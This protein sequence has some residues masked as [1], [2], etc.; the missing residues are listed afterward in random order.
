VTALESQPIEAQGR[1]ILQIAE[2]SSSGFQIPNPGKFGPSKGSFSLATEKE[3]VYL[4]DDERCVREA[5]TEMLESSGMRVISFASATEYL[6]YV[7]GDEPSCVVLDMRLPDMSGLEL[8]TRLSDLR[9]PPIIFISGLADIRSAVRA[10]RAGAVEF[11]LKPVNPDILRSAIRTAIARDRL[12]RKRQTE[13]DELQRRYSR[14]TP[15]ERE[16]LSLVVGGLLNKQSASVL[17]IS[18]ITL[19]IHRSQVMRKMEAESLAALVRMSLKLRIQDWRNGRI[20]QPN[21]S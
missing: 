3:L 1:S 15:R 18:E 11:L 13:L 12:I 16:V 17:G 14:L 21:D 8:Q 4:V 20:N 7:R 5:L 9:V 19:Q 10:I 6:T 2:A